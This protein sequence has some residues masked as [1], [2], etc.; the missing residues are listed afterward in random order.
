MITITV[1]LL[2]NVQDRDS[3]SAWKFSVADNLTSAIT[4][5]DE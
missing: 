2:M 5:E 1:T 4:S 3:K